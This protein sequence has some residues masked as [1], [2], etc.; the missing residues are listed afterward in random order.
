VG[1]RQVCGVAG[2]TLISRY[3]Y[4]GLECNTNLCNNYE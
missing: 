4:F 2:D 3:S 1:R